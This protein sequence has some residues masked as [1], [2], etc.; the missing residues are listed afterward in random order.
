ML[1]AVP[2]NT[3]LTY[4]PPRKNKYLVFPRDHIGVWWYLL[5]P[6]SIVASRL[7]FRPK[8]LE[9]ECHKLEVQQRIKIGKASKHWR[10]RFENL[11]GPSNGKL[12]EGEILNYLVSV[13]C[14]L[15]PLLL[16]LCLLLNHLT[17]ISD[18]YLSIS[19][20]IYVRERERVWAGPMYILTEHFATL[21]PQNP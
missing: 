15:G 16:T 5:L 18:I 19:R 17:S 9:K 2:I 7:D 12:S 3:F 1:C 11:V 21:Q 13:F 6:T 20:Y 14:C 10:S 4:F 8:E